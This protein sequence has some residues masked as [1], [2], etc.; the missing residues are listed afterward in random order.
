M[1]DF[2]KFLVSAA[3]RA[4]FNA[5]RARD[6]ARPSPLEGRTM[7]SWIGFLVQSPPNDGKSETGKES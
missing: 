6:V 1:E 3:A 4:H 2:P 5:P 7:K